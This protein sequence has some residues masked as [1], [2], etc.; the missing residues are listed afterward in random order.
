MQQLR[1]QTACN[2][3]AHSEAI[4][5]SSGKSR[6]RVR[7]QGQAATRVFVSRADPLSQM[8]VTQRCRL[9]LKDTGEKNGS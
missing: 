7:A 3:R 5:V 9:L 2:K 6:A 8:S 4:H 1:A